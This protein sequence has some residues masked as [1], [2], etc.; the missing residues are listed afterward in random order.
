MKTIVLMLG[1][2]F[3]GGVIIALRLLVSIALIWP[4]IVA[5]RW[6]DRRS[7][8]L[9]AL[10]VAGIVARATASVAL[11]TISFFRI[12][13]FTSL[14]LGDGFWK[15]AL[16][17]RSYYD[18]S[19]HAVAAGFGTI[20]DKLPSP[21]FLRALA[22]WMW[23]FGVS[24]A[25]AVLLNIACYAASAVLIVR[26]AG[27]QRAGRTPGPAAAGVALFALTFSPALLI[28][29]TQ[30]LKD[31]LCTM[32][33]ICVIAG[34]RLW[35]MGLN[36]DATRNLVMVG[37]GTLLMAV[38]I[39]GVAGIR[40]YAAVF[41]ITALAAAATYSIVVR[42]DAR[43]RLSAALL[44]AA[45]L[46]VLWFMFMTGA[47]PYAQAYQSSLWS[48]VTG[49]PGS[50]ATFD[51][52]RAGFE[53]AGGATSFGESPSSP[54][55]ASQQAHER[56]QEPPRR[57]ENAALPKPAVVMNVT[58]SDAAKPESVR[59]R[60]E[61]LWRGYAALF[62]PISVLRAT[63]IVKFEG[64]AG[65]LVI[66][67]IDTIVIDM[68][69]LAALCLFV[70]SARAHGISPGSVFV[71]VL[72]ILLSAS[73][74]YVVTNYGTLF[75]LRLL[76]VTPLWMLPVMLPNARAASKNDSELA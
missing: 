55:A 68:T 61:H 72:A 40:A 56:Q 31:P 28:F 62:V 13:V 47:G 11:F 26:C 3:G 58:A 1:L 25:S 34:A 53:D 8:L 59:A 39:Y 7:R 4:L 66:T 18:L 74:A 76:A 9:G 20:T 22:A 38:G 67:D 51:T 71:L 57:E 42:A 21:L 75:R 52:S 49:R 44:H 54:D 12:P 63:S 29:S 60:V 36:G 17:G 2:S 30:P 46:A 43:R 41:T 70:M 64:G 73:L 65:L 19:A 6:I 48:F 32:L 50:V 69:V 5:Y 24:P 35:W 15:L 27:R 14:Q 33:I 10:F 16:D 45:L 37:A 23:V